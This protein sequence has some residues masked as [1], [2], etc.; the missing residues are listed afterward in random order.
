MIS[1]FITGSGSLAKK[2]EKLSDDKLLCLITE[3]NDQVALEV[4]FSRYVHIVFAACM[5]Y[6][7]DEDTARDAAMEIFEN[8]PEKLSKSPVKYFKSWLYVT[9]KNH[10]LMLLRKQK[11]YTDAELIENTKVLA[12][13]DTSEIN[14]KKEEENR[15]NILLNC[16]SKLKGEQ[17]ICLELMYLQD[18][19]YSDISV[20]TGFS[21][22]S[23][24]SYIQNGKRN[25]KIMLEGFDEFSR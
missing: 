2:L 15:Y 12:T 20:K 9:V 5:K 17:K 13:N 16:L 8:L 24:K 1:K 23:V 11:K 22:N 18:Y 7:K 10:C 6:L 14:I 25:L 3:Q 21:L 4:I 19:C